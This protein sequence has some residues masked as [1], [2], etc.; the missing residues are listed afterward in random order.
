[1]RC[2]FAPDGVSLVRLASLAAVAIVLSAPS[3]G[4]GTLDE[5]RERDRLNCGVSKDTPGFASRAADG[6]W[7]G[8]D[9]DTCRAVAASVL[10]D[11]DKVTYTGLSSKERFTTL[12]AGGVDMLADVATWTLQRD[13]GLGA[14]FVGVN[15]YDGQGFMVRKDI[16]VSSAKELDGAAICV[17]RGTTTELNLSDFFRLNGLE[18]RPVHFDRS[19]NAAVAYERGRCDAVTNDR[20]A[21][22]AYRSQF[23]DPDIHIILPDILSKEPLGPVVRHGDDQ[24]FDVVKWTLF[25][26]FQAEESGVSSQNVD[27][28]KTSDDP[29]VRR[30]LG[31]SGDMGEQLGL[32]ADWG[33]QIVKQVGNYSEIYERNVGPNTSIG[34]DRGINALWSDGG[35]MY[36]MPFR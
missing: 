8:L 34:M 23:K 16:G 22:A 11:A 20:S 6:G 14:N 29:N 33:Y 9:V 19:A 30:L 1:M 17:T 4:A 28:M 26:L 21:L 12:Q 15:F 7:V 35:L 5:V 2:G 32:T 13:A 24:W 18:F 31:V 27:E 3:A 10:G 36:A 25:A